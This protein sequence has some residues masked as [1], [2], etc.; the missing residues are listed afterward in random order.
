MGGVGVGR[1]RVEH[2]GVGGI[3]IE[4]I[5]VITAVTMV[6]LIPIGYNG[7]LQRLLCLSYGLCYRWIH[8][9]VF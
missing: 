6:L 5:I 1:G 4:A 7:C 2:R 9:A 3:I 8:F